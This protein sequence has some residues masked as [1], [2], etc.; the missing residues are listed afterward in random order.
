MI[1]Y[2]SRFEVLFYDE[3]REI[4]ELKKELNSPNSYKWDSP[5]HGLLKCNVD[6]SWSSEQGSCGFGLVLRDERGDMKWCGAKTYHALL[7][8]LEAAAATLTW[9]GQ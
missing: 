8:R 6:A 2:G 9:P 5:P 3:E 7:S 1:D 4:P